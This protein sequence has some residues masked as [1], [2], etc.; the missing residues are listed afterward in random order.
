MGKYASSK[1]NYHL[2]QKNNPS[3]S[4][5]LFYIES[6]EKT[7]HLD[8]TNCQVG[9]S[10]NRRTPKWM[11]YNGKPY[12][13]MDDLGGKSTIFGNIQIFTGKSSL[14]TASC[15][16][17]GPHLTRLTWSFPFAQLHEL[18][19]IG[20]NPPKFGGFTEGS[21]TKKIWQKR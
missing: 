16:K 18:L 13:L 2:P 4:K 21:P 6:L 20:S 19:P 11:V 12:F 14:A 7:H 15:V 1:R 3:I 10:K 17:P 5:C 8:N 9:V